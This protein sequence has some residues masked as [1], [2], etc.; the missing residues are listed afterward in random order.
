MLGLLLTRWR[1]VIK[2]LDLDERN[3]WL[4]LAPL[5]R[6][7]YY[8]SHTTENTLFRKTLT[9]AIAAGILGCSHYEVTTLEDWCDQ[10]AGVD[11]IKKHEPFWSVLPA[12]SF[13]GD[14]IRDSYT[15]LMDSL[16]LAKVEHRADRMA[17]R[18][19]T[20][21]HMEN[22][23]T[24]MEVDPDT[25]ISE[26]REGIE[27]AQSGESL[28]YGDRC[29]FGGLI[30]LFDTLYIHSGEWDAMGLTQVADHITALDTKR[31]ATQ[32]NPI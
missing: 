12:I 14:A 2:R 22:L 25:I 1:S 17:W 30:S 31:R 27:R 26:W 21:L 20:V 16:G 13:Y 23:S 28:D 7:T 19:G 18:E 5:D 6:T 9:F 24:L 29:V 32:K 15:A 4:C 11:L 3:Q 8:S 10:I